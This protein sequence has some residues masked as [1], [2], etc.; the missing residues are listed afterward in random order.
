MLTKIISGGQTGV[1]RAGL[2]AARF[3]PHLQWGGWCPL[4]RIC[5]MPEGKIPDQYFNQGKNGLAESSSDRYP[6][7]TAWNVRDADATICMRAGRLTPGTQKTILEC[8]KQ[9]KS[10][11]ICDPHYPHTQVKTAKWI[12]ENNISILNIAGPRASK[13]A[14]IYD[15]AFSYLKSVIYLCWL[16]DVKKISFWEFGPVDKYYKSKGDTC[17]SKKN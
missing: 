9:Q 3:Y 11:W 10:Y 12:C 17:N 1:D 4:G 8:R 7:R 5:E 15:A 14:S 16:H 13:N 2:D 6:Q